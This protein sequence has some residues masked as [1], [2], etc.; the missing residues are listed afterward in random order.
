MAGSSAKANNLYPSGDG[1]RPSGE[2][3]RRSGW[4]GAATAARVSQNTTPPS[5]RDHVLSYVDL[6]KLK[7]LSIVCNGG[8]GGAGTVLDLL[9]KQLPFRFTKVHH[10]PDGNFPNGVPNPM[11]EENQEVT[12]R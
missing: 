11:L 10:Q 7:P 8:N 2:D 4:P 1:C 9:E 6:A 5:W 3:T 12:G